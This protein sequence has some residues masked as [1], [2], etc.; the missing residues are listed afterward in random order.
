[1]FIRKNS[2]ALLLTTLLL[3]TT[4]DK[5]L[6]T[7]KHSVARVWNEALLH[8]IRNDYARPTSHA[9]NLFH[10][11]AAMYD[12]WAIFHPPAS[13]YFLG[14][15]QANG[16]HCEFSEQQRNAFINAGTSAE[17]RQKYVEVTLSS[18]MYHLI[19]HRFEK[20][21]GATSIR[22][23]LN[24]VLNKLGI[25]VNHNQAPTLSS[26][27]GLGNYLA[28]CIIEY[29]LQ[30]G[31]NEANQ[32]KNRFYQPV[33]APLNPASVGN[34]GMQKPDRWQPLTIDNYVDQSGNPL[35][36]PEFLGAEWG[37]VEPFALSPSDSVL[38]KREGH[39]YRVYL[40]PGQPSLFTGDSAD[41]AWGHSMVAVW[42]SQLDPADGTRW[43]ISPAS[44]GASASLP[45]SDDLQNFYQYIDGGTKQIGR[46]INPY[47]N[48]P[49]APNQALRGDYTR[50]VA[51]YWADGP[52]SETPPGHWFTILNEF[53]LDHPDFHRQY[54]GTGSALN[55]LEFDIRSYF[56]LGGAMHDA[57]IAAWSNKGYYD[58]ARPVSALRYMAGLGQRSNP[59]L[60]SYHQHGIPLL[61]NYIELVY[62]TDPLAGNDN[63]QV[64]KIKIRAWKGPDHIS[65]RYE[66]N[67]GVGWI[68]AENWWPYQ[69]PTF[70]TPP[71]SGYVS[72]HSTF[73]RAAAEVLTTITG[74]EYFP[75]GLAEFVAKQNDFLVFEQGPSEDVILQWATFQ[76]ASDQSSLSRIWGGIHPPIDDVPGR[77]IGIQVA[78]RAV[79]LAATYFR[80]QPANPSNTGSLNVA[81][82]ECAVIATHDE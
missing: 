77:K 36:T 29:G 28:Q 18:A 37:N 56:T 44:L 46:Q 55:E 64:G 15:T 60:P 71:F 4:A 6:A 66:N 82:N 14:R 25:T 19:S 76:D 1:M 78:E 72:G 57:A 24:R 54:C 8:A 13:P 10:A 63:R 69:R 67:A 59:S 62:P 47:T 42:S 11:S 48:E 16:F 45:E 7:E 74:T 40:N 30:D 23:R 32:F 52:D 39:E 12:A 26:A 21:P 80:G 5:S 35:P 22:I 38:M 75:G 61:D 31:S 34:S 51:E 43:D 17:Q 68:L 41:Y 9:R 70:V 27:E 49:Y 3:T 65:N 50:V 58:Y 81:D 2:A 79:R 33:N 20:S 73:S 53:V